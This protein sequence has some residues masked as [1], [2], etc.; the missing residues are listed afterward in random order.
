MKNILLIIYIGIN[1]LCL[2]SVHALDLP[3]NEWIL[4]LYNGAEA[5]YSNGLVS[6]TIPGD[7]YWNVQLTRKD[8]SLQ[9]GHTYA[10]TF[11][12]QTFTGNRSVEVRIGRD[13]FP[14][15]AFGEFG[16]V[17]ATVAGKTYTKQFEM[18]SADVSNARFEFNV[19]KYS[20]SVYISDV[21]LTCLDCSENTSDETTTEVAGSSERLLDADTVSLAD[22]TKT[23]G[24]DIYG[25]VLEFG[26]DSKVYG[27][28]GAASCTLRER[29]TVTGSFTSPVSCTEQNGI[30][31][32]TRITGTLSR[33]TLSVA[34][35]TQGTEIISIGLDESRTLSPG[36]YGAF[37]ANARS[38]VEFSSGEYVFSNFYTEPDVSL[39]FDLSDGP[40]TIAV[41]DGVRFGDRNVS[42]ISGGNPSEI[43]WLVGSGD[44]NFGTDGKY[45]GKIVA[46]ESYVR[47]PSRSHLVGGVY[48]RSFRMEPQSTLSMEPRADEISY[49]GEHFSPFYSS[50]VYRYSAVL[51]LSADSVEMFVYADSVFSVLVNDEATRMAA[52][53]AQ[54]NDVAVNLSRT[55]MDGFPAEAFSADYVF[56][57]TKSSKYRVYWNP[58]S[59]CASDCDGSTSANA[60]SD[61]ST[62]LALVLSSGRELVMTGGVWDASAL[63][64]DGVVPWKVG[65]EMVGYESDLWDASSEDAIPKIELGSDAHIEI[66]GKSPRSLT[67]FRFVDG[68]NADN[69]GAVEADDVERLSM[70]SVIFYKSISAGNGGALYAGDTLYLTNARF[71][72]DS[73]ANSGG[74]VYAGG[75]S[76]ILN[77]VFM[78]NSSIEDGSAIKSNA[79]ASVK[80]SIF[81]SNVTGGAGTLRNDDSLELWNVL[82]YGNIATKGH[83][84]VG[85][86]G[87]GVIA[88]S[89]FWKNTSSC[90]AEGCSD[91][92]VPGFVARNSSFSTAYEGSNIYVGDP[93][94]LDEDNPVGDNKFMDYAAGLNLSTNSPLKTFGV[95][96]SS[97]PTE[98]ILG[99]ER[100]GDSIPLGPY[101][102]TISS[103]NYVFGELQSDGSVGVVLPAVPIIDAFPDDYVVRYLA[104]SKLARVIKGYVKKH[105]KTKVSKAEVRF[106]LQNSEGQS[107]DDVPSMTLTF[108][109]NGEE[110][111]KY[112]FQTMVLSGD[113]LKGKPILF[114]SRPEDQGERDDAIILC[115]KSATDI[116]SIKVTDY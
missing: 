25:T 49:D 109:R 54:S 33:D 10:A 57:F 65:F 20:G 8:L 113:T 91:E 41:V 27:N 78:D 1:F 81:Y 84:A 87:A 51:P 110:N 59:S 105:S 40:I 72:L 68:Y 114:S 90:S 30:S 11:T 75:R 66:Y 86:L 7:D 100:S 45:F 12:L 106:T 36:T 85:G 95:L 115:V 93:E 80:N 6:I 108:Y 62:A 79:S 43:S 53:D 39:V 102:W 60:F 63:Y 76:Y 4:G 99:G 14:Y 16:T 29:A 77:A 55:L 37:Y 58:Q 112:V 44:V 89:I 23:L 26:A 98:D 17:T 2:K 38:T 15:D 101:A 92:V 64:T 71:E 3:E 47:V 5:V 22:N 24:G 50:A 94:F 104:K 61:F 19:G 97:V 28:A 83:P 111:G 35:I 69:G 13:G 56:H 82:F 48:A 107:Y 70:S 88:N 96:E 31:I 46:P 74:A 52:L 67:G 73:A 32:G 9:Y 42:T 103:G 18:S 34:S 21:S 116:F